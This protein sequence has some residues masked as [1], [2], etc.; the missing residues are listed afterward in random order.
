M[1]VCMH[2]CV[3]VCAWHDP[4]MYITTRSLPLVP[5]TCVYECIYVTW[6]IHAWHLHVLQPWRHFLSR[7]Y[8]IR[9][10][11]SVHVCFCVFTSIVVCSYVFTSIVVCSYVFMRAYECLCVFLCVYVCMTWPI[12]V[13][14]DTMSLAGALHVC[15]CVFMCVSVCWCVFMCI[16]VC[17]CVHDMTH[18]CICHILFVCLMEHIWYTYAIYD[19]YMSDMSYEAPTL[20]HEQIYVYVR[21]VI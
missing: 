10:F 6:L 1:S 14:S 11:T 21:Y 4:F 17:L 20:T 16:S 3:F 5:Y 2:F 13:Y 9:V 8:I 15:F 7:W 19:M 12:H 18:S